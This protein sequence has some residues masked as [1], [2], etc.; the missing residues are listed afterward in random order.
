[1]A[2]TLGIIPDFDIFL[3]SLGF[4][5][6]LWTHSLLFWLP[7]SAILYWR[8]KR[9]SLPLTLGIYSHMLTDALVGDIPALY[10]LLDWTIGLGLPIPS[11]FDALLE[12]GGLLLALSYMYGNGDLKD[13]LKADR[14]NITLAIPFLIILTLSTLFA[15]H[16]NISIITYGF[17]RLA[18]TAITQGHLALL[19]VISIGIITGIR[20]YWDDYTKPH[21]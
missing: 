5:H 13:L 17:S 19:L 3:Q 9:N 21:H 11:A 20:A 7:P 18:M 15:E 6:H 12:V 16:N 2:L 14:R 10:P 4:E 8:M 1:M